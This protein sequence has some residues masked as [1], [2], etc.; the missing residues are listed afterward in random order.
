MFLQSCHHFDSSSKASFA[1]SVYEKIKYG[2]V[3]KKSVRQQ[4]GLQAMIRA[5]HISEGK[6]SVIIISKNIDSRPVFLH[7]RTDHIRRHAI[8][9]HLHLRTRLTII[10]AQRRGQHSS[11]LITKILEKKIIMAITFGSGF[12]LRVCK[13]Q[14]QDGIFDI[15]A[16]LAPFHIF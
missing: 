11:P 7:D 9:C 1:V 13:Q 14:K 2:A 4:P 8:R 12:R 16:F 6:S 5:A 3:V 10:F 15:L